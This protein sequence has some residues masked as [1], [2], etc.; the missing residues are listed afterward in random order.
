MKYVILILSALFMISCSSTKNMSNGTIYKTDENKELIYKHYENNLTKWTTPYEIINIETK[1]GKTNIIA[2]GDTSNSPVLLIHAMG[3][4]ATMWFP[5]VAELSKT[6]RVYAINTIGDLGKSELS[7]MDNYPKN[8][9]NYS[10]WLNKILNELNIDKCDVVGASMGGWISMNFAI[11]SP[12]KVEHLILL[13]PMGIKANTFGVMRRL[14]K[15]LFFPTQKNKEAV[16]EWVLGDN[17]K[18]DEMATYMNIAM[19]C[20]GKMPIPKR[21]KKRQL[22]KIKA[23]TLLVLGTQDNPIGKP[24]KNSK[25][26][27]KNIQNVKVEIVKTGH[28]MNVEKPSKINSLIIKFLKN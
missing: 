28:L 24:Q 23:Q 2:S 13:G 1:Y 18:V 20:E 21:I 19:N 10:E 17:K 15:V 25:F 5:N 22:K 4:T 14:F 26:A 16:T 3:V 12:D 11:N 7:D 9:Q 8:G 6:H 27:N